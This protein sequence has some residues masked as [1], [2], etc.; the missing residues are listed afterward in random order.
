MN[1]LYNFLPISAI[2][3]LRIYQNCLF[4]S[5][6]NWFSFLLFLVGFTTQALLQAFFPTY[7]SFFSAQTHCPPSYSELRFH[8]FRNFLCLFCEQQPTSNSLL[9]LTQA[10]SGCLEFISF[11]SL[12]SP[13]S[14]SVSFSHWKHLQFCN[15]AH[16]EFPSLLFSEAFKAWIAYTRNI[17]VISN[18]FYLFWM[19]FE[20]SHWY[21]FEQ[22]LWDLASVMNSEYE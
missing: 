8:W 17:L 22:I 5:L 18:E 15:L 12:A 4:V 21:R 20:F 2:T 11:C 7:Q 9:L 13:S 6:L 10:A 1:K 14:F 3:V 19:Q 16:S